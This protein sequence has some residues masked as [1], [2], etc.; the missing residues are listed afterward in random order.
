MAVV[1]IDDELVRHRVVRVQLEGDHVTLLDRERRSR[2]RNAVGTLPPT[3]GCGETAVEGDRHGLRWAGSDR[4][5]RPQGRTPKPGA[6]AATPEARWED[7]F[8]VT[9]HAP[10]LPRAHPISPD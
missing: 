5:H 7:R 6:A 1:H 10:S 3:R 9:R 4:G 8:G 2:L